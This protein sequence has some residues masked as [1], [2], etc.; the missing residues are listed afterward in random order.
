MT[1]MLEQDSWKKAAQKKARRYQETSQESDNQFLERKPRIPRNLQQFSNRTRDDFIF[2]KLLQRCYGRIPNHGQGQGQY[3]IRPQVKCPH[4]KHWSQ[5]ELWKAWCMQSGSCI[6]KATCHN[7]IKRI[8][9][10]TS[11]VA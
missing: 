4:G 3:D 1:P 11:V 5:G 8:G 9:R 6:P 2:V 10:L 7:L